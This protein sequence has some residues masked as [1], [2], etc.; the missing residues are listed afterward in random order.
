MSA[1]LSIGAKTLA[2]MLNDQF[3]ARREERG[4]V[5]SLALLLPNPVRNK[6]RAGVHP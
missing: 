5:V 3:S 1:R 6:A 2:Q 4:L